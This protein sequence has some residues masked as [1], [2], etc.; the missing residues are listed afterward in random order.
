MQGNVLS[1]L[2]N[3]ELTGENTKHKCKFSLHYSTNLLY[4]L[5]RDPSIGIASHII[6]FS[7]IGNKFGISP[8]FNKLQIYSTIDSSDI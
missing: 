4:F 5:L 1:L 3:S 6:N 7:S 2:L 8:L